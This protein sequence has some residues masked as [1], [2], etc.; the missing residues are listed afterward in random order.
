MRHIFSRSTPVM[1]YATY[2]SPMLN[3]AHMT[4]PSTLR[5]VAAK[6][7]LI[8]LALERIVGYSTL[9]MVMW[10]MN[11]ELILEPQEQEVIYDLRISGSN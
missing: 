11:S 6:N 3:Y 7:S 5:A 1:L 4:V 8:K 10:H 9:M 2:A